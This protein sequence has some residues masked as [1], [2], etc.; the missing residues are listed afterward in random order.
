MRVNKFASTAAPG[1][2]RC[3]QVGTHIITVAFPQNAQPV[4]YCFRIS[5]ECNAD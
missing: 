2:L 4:I 1:S 3:I 5:L